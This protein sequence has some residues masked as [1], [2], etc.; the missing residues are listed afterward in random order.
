VAF[1]QAA[2]TMLQVEIG[3]LQGDSPGTRWATAAGPGGENAS[4]PERELHRGA[5]GG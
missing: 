2:L 3:S 1:L 4:R 5:S